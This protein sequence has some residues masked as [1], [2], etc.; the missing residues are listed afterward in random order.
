MA[1]AG[2]VGT[3]LT[4]MLVAIIAAASAA[5]ATDKA[6]N[7]ISNGSFD[8]PEDP[9]RGW[10]VDYAWTGN[11]HYVGN[12]G[13]ISIVPAENGRKNV[14]RL[15]SSSDAGTKAESSLIP[16]DPNGRYR[17]TLFVKGG[18]YRICIAGY[19]W[20]PGIRPHENPKPEELRRA[21]LGKAE[22]G[23]AGSWQPIVLEIPGANASDT[24]VQHL[25]KVQFIRLFAL[26]V[27]AGFIDDI[28][29]TRTN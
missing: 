1:K 7:L 11:S 3:R 23:I 21:Y 20:K 17:A 26:F 8:D 13:N 9:L 22:T 25:R 29:I 6:E 24:S 5:E 10:L 4:L 19:Q 2:R 27:G 28:V 15:V 14:M 12:I 18:M 16:F